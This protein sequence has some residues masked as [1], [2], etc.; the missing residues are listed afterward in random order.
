MEAALRR[1]NAL[2]RPKEDPVCGQREARSLEAEPCLPAPRVFSGRWVPGSPGPDMGV[3][4]G[5]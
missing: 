3:A 2:I 5:D 1:E 4:H